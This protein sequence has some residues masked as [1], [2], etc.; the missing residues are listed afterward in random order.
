MR[1][2]AT[3]CWCFRPHLH[4]ALGNTL[5]QIVEVFNFHL[6][7]KITPGGLVPMWYRLQ[8]ILHVWYEEIRQQALKSAVLHA[9][10]THLARRR[11]NLLAVVLHNARFDLLYDRSF[12]RQPGPAE[13][14]DGRV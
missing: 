6:Q 1:R 4:Y 5:S 12:A 10:E 7:L 11:Q 9:D 2:W 3:A 13:V 8:A 14:L